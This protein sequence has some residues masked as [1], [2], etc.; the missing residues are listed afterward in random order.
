MGFRF[1]GTV[2][3]NQISLVRVGRAGAPRSRTAMRREWSVCG[4]RVT[5]DSEVRR[6]RVEA[7][8]SIA[9]GRAVWSRNSDPAGA[10]TSPHAVLD[11][12]SGHIKLVEL[13]SS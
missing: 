9:Y 11:G 8:V 4:V 1:A 3:K 6:A 7:R 10:S 12:G 5:F 2:Y 13:A